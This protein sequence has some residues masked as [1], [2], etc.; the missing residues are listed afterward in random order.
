MIKKEV[1]T[2]MENFISLLNVVIS[3]YLSIYFLDLLFWFL[4]AFFGLG[5]GDQS[6]TM[7]W[8]STNQ[9]GSWMPTISS[10]SP[11]KLSTNCKYH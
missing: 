8:N 1:L 9:M 2:V 6:T 5:D 11:V 4:Y 10:V 7:I 3:F